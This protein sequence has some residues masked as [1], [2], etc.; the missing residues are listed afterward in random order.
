MELWRVEPWKVF[1]ALGTENVENVKDDL[2][3]GV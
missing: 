2:P 3:V 1:V